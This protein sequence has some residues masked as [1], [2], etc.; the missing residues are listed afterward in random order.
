MFESLAACSRCGVSTEGDRLVLRW[1]LADYQAH[2]S[3]SG[4]ASREEEEHRQICRASTG[5]GDAA[6]FGVPWFSS[7]GGVGFHS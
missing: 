5:F 2:S 1:R 7:N 3:P 4:A 6:V